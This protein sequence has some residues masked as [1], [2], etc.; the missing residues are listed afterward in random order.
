MKRDKTRTMVEVAMLG[1]IA[2]IL[3]L[4]EFPLPFLAPSFYELDFSEV[5]VLVGAFAIGPMA[6]VAIE[7]IKILLNLVIN[8]T[9]TGGVGE[10][11]NFILG[12][13]YML[14]AALIYKHK[15]TKKTA[16]AGM[17]VG[18]VVL[19]VVACF[20]NVFF[21]LPA[22]GS[23]FGMPVEAFVEMAQAI[24][25]SIQ[26]MVGFALLCVAP[27]NLLKGVVVSVITALLYKHISPILKG[28]R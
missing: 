19:V 20:I 24:N 8:G 15:K 9:I 25:S 6:G 21:L 11:A 16:I 17:A 28:H 22:Y 1:A 23:A 12:V 10:L 4:F 18:T 3:M 13:C 26:D 27:F 14:P 7:A 2:V 5:P